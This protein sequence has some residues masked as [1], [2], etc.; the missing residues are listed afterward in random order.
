MF[1][2]QNQILNYFIIKNILL[3][4]I[5]KTPKRM[6]NGK[7]KANNILICHMYACTC[8]TKVQLGWDLT[9][10]IY[11][12]SKC[13]FRKLRI[14][15]KSMEKSKCITEI[16]KRGTLTHSIKCVYIPMILSIYVGKSYWNVQFALTTSILNQK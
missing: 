4:K 11:L 8:G 6:L 2:F 16:D 7:K 15:T 1:S 13:L 5:K 9:L 10:F 12:K 14:L 3:L